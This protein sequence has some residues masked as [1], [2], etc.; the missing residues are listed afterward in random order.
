MREGSSVKAG[1]AAS[2]IFTL[3][4]DFR[5]LH[6]GVL[7]VGS[8][9]ALMGEFGITS[10]AVRQ[11]LSR[12]VT[13]GWL[14]RTKDNGRASYAL[15]ARGAGRIAQ[16]APRIYEPAAEWDGRWRIVIYG[17]SEKARQLRDR[18]RKDLTL[19]GLAPFAPSVWISPRDVRAEIFQLVQQP[20]LATGIQLFVGDYEGPASDREL[21]ER[22]WGVDAIA[23]A[24]REFIAQYEPRLERERAAHSL[25]ER[26][27]F[28][29]R[30]R[31]VQDFRRF[32]YIDPGLPSVL[33][34]P[35]WPGSVA[36]GL[37]RQYYALIASK[38]ERFFLSTLR[39]REGASGSRLPHR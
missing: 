21:L 33:L 16:I 1:R 15:T 20:A 23:A 12:M 3:F 32:L 36:S 39:P 26:E 8:L 10:Q 7:P 5:E 25:T 11:A 18:L 38:A 34:R 28:V 19:L 24:Y 2:L 9:V 6:N 29:E 35:H 30:L 4:G 13:H 14:K 37:F 27:A 17:I 22:S 31:L